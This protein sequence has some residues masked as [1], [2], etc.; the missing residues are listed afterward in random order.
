MSGAPSMS[1]RQPGAVHLLP[2]GRDTAKPSRFEDRAL[3]GLGNVDAAEPRG[4]R[5]IVGDRRCRAIG[6]RAGAHHFRSL[7]AADLEDQ[8]GQQ[9]QPG[10]EERRID[11]A[12]EPAARVRGEAEL[13][14]GRA[15]PLGIEIGDLEQHVGGRSR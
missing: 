10:V 3:L 9:L 7:A 1:G 2:V 4:Q 5:R 13:A 12:L 11:P 15:D 8:R 14:P 6:R